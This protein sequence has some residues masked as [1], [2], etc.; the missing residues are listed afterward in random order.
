LAACYYEP[1]PEFA[2]E[3]LFDSLAAAAERVDPALAER[4]RHL[5]EAFA[6]QSLDSLR[7]DYTRLF[8]GPSDIYT[9]PYAAVWTEQETDVASIYSKAGFAVGEDSHERPDHIAVELEFLYRLVY[10]AADDTRRRFVGQHLAKWIAPFSAVLQTDAQTAF[11]R[12]LAQLTE[13]VVALEAAT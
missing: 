2:E 10:H 6:E 9:R 4:A 7:V 3:R 1:R 5:G 13:R 12:E 11:Y 8:V